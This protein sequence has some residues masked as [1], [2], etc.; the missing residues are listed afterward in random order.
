V[1]G[2][3]LRYRSASSTTWSEAKALTSG[4]PLSLDITPDMCD[5]PHDKTSRWAFQLVPAQG[6]VMEGSLHLRIDMVRLHDLSLWP[7]HAML[8]GGAHTLTLFE[9]QATS[10]HQGAATAIA[11]RVANQGQ[12]QPQGV[13]ATK[14][15]P[16]ETMAMTANVTITDATAQVGQVRNISFLYKPADSNGF[17]RANVTH[18]DL[19]KGVF[20]FT[21][22]VKMTQTDSPY[23]KT[24]QWRFD[25]Q[26]ATSDPT[27]VFGNC[28]GCSDAQVQY[29]L[30]VVA[31]DAV[32]PKLPD[33]GASGP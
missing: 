14:V 32:D 10:S 20:Q 15:V 27:G 21:W 1:T 18:A 24:S 28:Q 2:V 19:A 11:D 29:K 12:D 6:Q 31:Y 9:G 23:A 26:I 3:T 16:M 17:R 7:G 8:F 22:P 25:L 30:E 13:A 4:A 5:M 33:A